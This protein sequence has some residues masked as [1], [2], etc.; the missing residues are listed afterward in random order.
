MNEILSSPPTALAKNKGIEEV[1]AHMLNLP[2]AD[3]PVQH[4]FGP[5]IYIREVT[6][7]SGIIAIGH[8][9]KFH[10]LNVMLTGKVAMIK[11]GDVQV[12]S[13]P[14]IFVGEPGRK[15][16]YVIET[17]VWLNV[18]ATEETDIE[19]LE[20]Y[21]FEKSDTWESHKE[22]MED[23]LYVLHK[24]DRDD[25][26]QALKDVGFDAETVR[27]QSEN[28]EDQIPFPKGSGFNRIVVVRESPIEGK[29]LFLSWPVEKDFF[30]APAR[31]NGKRT[32]A[33]RY[34]NHSKNPNCKYVRLDSGA[35]WLVS[36][37]DIHGCKG[38]DSGC[39]LTVD[40]RQSV[41]LVKE[42]GVICPE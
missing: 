17:C 42:E 30:I 11:D 19:K 36:K 8:T 32:P 15:I 41:S 26:E 10:Q 6:L 38:G 21:Y 1:E 5:G 22:S 39:E 2:Q 20:E 4:H 29:G 18:Y 14:M 7:P 16:G 35:I 24:E 12:V 13:A 3:C 25:F 31:I 33:G 23:F 37:Q 34:V 28:E 40:Y 27:K 9:Q